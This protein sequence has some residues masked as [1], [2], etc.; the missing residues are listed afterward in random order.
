MLKIII[1]TTTTN[2]KAARARMQRR[3][4]VR[5]THIRTRVDV[6]GVSASLARE[7]CSSALALFFDPG[8]KL[9]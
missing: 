6:D 7:R 4:R 5:G 2:F 3:R 9:G 1:Y 8:L